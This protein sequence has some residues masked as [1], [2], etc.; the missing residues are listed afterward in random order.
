MS[1]IL[2]RTAHW[3]RQ[4]VN[5]YFNNV[6]HIEITK[7]YFYYTFILEE[8]RLTILGYLLC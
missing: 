8:Y 1:Y 3:Y 7:F 4:G 5:E 6:E 2:L